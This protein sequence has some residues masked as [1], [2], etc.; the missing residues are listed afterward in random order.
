V[1]AVSLSQSSERQPKAGKK[2]KIH[3][4][5]TG[6]LF[7]LILRGA[8]RSVMLRLKTIKDFESLSSSSCGGNGKRSSMDASNLG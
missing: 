6:N 2:R 7:P 8:L 3:R 1:P 5:R 4:D